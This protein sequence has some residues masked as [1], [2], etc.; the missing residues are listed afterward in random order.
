MTR[1]DDRSWPGAGATSVSRGGRSLGSSCRRRQRSIRDNVNLGC[2]A[3]RRQ[4][5]LA[6]VLRRCVSGMP[7]HKPHYPFEALSWSMLC[8][9]KPTTSVAMAPAASPVS[10]WI[11]NISAGLGSF[12][13]GGP[14]PTC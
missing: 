13:D 2:L 1:G 3:A 7:H 6:S 14:E 10:A 4:H 8:L 12:N 5:P 9:M 11:M